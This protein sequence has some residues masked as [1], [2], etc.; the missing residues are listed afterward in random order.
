MLHHSV[1]AAM[2][3]GSMLTNLVFPMTSSA[4]AVTRCLA[5]TVVVHRAFSG[6][7]WTFMVRIHRIVVQNAGCHG[8]RRLIHRA[9]AAF[10]RSNG[11]LGTYLAVRPWECE[12]FRPFGD[13]RGHFMW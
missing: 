3:V 4:S 6:Q 7:E 2:V 9:D 10:F 5:Y 13:G 11:Q 8:I 12:T 1:T